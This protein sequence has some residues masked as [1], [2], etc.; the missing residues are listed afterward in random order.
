MFISKIH[1]RVAEQGQILLTLVLVVLVSLTIGL[2]ISQRAITNL[3]TSTKTEQ[4]SRAFSAAEAG[5]EQALRT[6]AEVPNL[7]F[8]NQS[9]A[10][11][12]S[13]G[14]LPVYRQALEYPPISKADFG[15]IWLAKPQ[16]LTYY[17]SQDTLSVFFGNAGQDY[18]NDDTKPAIE[19]NLV[20]QDGNNYLSTRYYFDSDLSRITGNNFIHPNQALDPRHQYSGD[21]CQTEAEAVEN[22]SQGDPFCINSSNSLSAPLPE[23]RRFLCKVT[24]S[25]KPNDPNEIPIL[26]RFRLLYSNTKQRF[27]F[28]PVTAGCQTDDYICSLPPQ[29]V[30]YTSVGTSGDT[31]RRIQTFQETTVVPQFIDYAIF[32]NGS[33]NK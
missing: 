29:A 25:T 23:D 13:T 24:I 5:I 17:Y 12:S 30:I 31:Q 11:V 6:N 19:I 32:S 1:P 3:S 26:V 15:Q 22:C 21:R 14:L 28:K 16:D 2:S 4:S 27:A 7:S 10:T 33:I 20:T 18:S 8:D 9:K